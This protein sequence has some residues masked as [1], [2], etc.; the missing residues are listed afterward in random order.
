MVYYY[1]FTDDEVNHKTTSVLC[2]KQTRI[3]TTD[4][5]DGCEA[6]R[7]IEVDNALGNAQPPQYAGTIKHTAA[8]LENVDPHADLSGPTGR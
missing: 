7:E 2:Q 8:E 6:D 5:E 4:N 1:S 3:R